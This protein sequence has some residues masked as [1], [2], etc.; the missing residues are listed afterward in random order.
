MGPCVPTSITVTG[1]PSAAVSTPAA[2]LA[3][4][5]VSLGVGDTLAGVAPPAAPAPA[6][7]L[8][9]LD[10]RR[11]DAEREPRRRDDDEEGLRAWMVQSAT[12]TATAAATH[13]ACSSSAGD[14]EEAEAATTGGVRSD[15][16][17][18]AGCALAIGMK[19]GKLR[20]EGD[21]A[22]LSGYPAAAH[23]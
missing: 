7:P 5:A 6:T 21:Q 4:A 8:S 9:L 3:L 19:E 2:P 20:V 16:D 10:P 18:V 12:Q 15:D 17:D 13:A 23:C 11:L 14:D 22:G 1:P